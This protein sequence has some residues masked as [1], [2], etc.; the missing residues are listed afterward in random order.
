MNNLVSVVVPV[1]NVRPYLERCISSLIKQTYT[2]IQII[3]VDDGSDDG[4][5]E[6]CDEIKARDNRIEIIHQKNGGLSA[7]RNTGLKYI[8]GEYIFFLDSDDYISTD[9]IEK[10]LSCLLKNNLDIVC[11]NRVLFWDNNKQ[12]VQYDQIDSLLVMDPKNAII[13]MNR[14]KYID[15][16]A[17]SKLF[18][19]ELFNSIKF[20][21]GKLS[22]DMF[23]MYKIFEIADKVGYISEP[24]LY[25]YQRKGSISKSKKINFDFVE[26]CKEQM[27]YVSHKYPD[28]KLY[29]EGVYIISNLTVYN[30]VIG[31]GGKIS[32]SNFKKIR[33][34]IEMYYSKDCVKELSS[35]RKF[36]IKLFRFNRLIYNIFIMLYKNM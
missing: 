18:K 33:E 29:M 3:I 19:K 20:P 16:S 10:M 28:L 34:N 22:E 21:V 7:A 1:Y 13:E 5:S 2:N 4:S 17:H 32:K 26:A 24:L 6:L 30:A 9:A 31:Y 11:C 23:I 25:Y 14:Y 15:M 36:E 8:K 35:I 27:V 12:K